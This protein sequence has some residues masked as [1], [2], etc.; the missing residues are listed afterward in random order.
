M[1]STTLLVLAF[2]VLMLLIGG[3]L[4]YIG[5]LTKARNRAC[6]VSAMENLEDNSSS[7]SIAFQ[8]VL[9]HHS[10]QND[11]VG[12]QVTVIFSD[13]RSWNGAAGYADIA[14]HCPLA[15][16]H[17]LY[18]G[19]ITKLFTA[20]LVMK[21][22]ENGS[23][24]LDQKINQWIQLP[25]AA[26]IT[27]RNL[28]SHTSGLPDYARDTWFQIRWFGLPSRMWEPDELIRVIQNKPV[29]FSPGSRYEYSNSNY[30]LLGMMLEKATEKPYPTILAENVSANL[31]MQD[32]YFLNYQDD[33]S[34]ANGYDKT[35][36]HLGRRN[37]T[38][39]R[40]SL[41]SGAYA[42]GGM[43]SNSQDVARF[44]HALFNGQVISNVS[45]ATM[46]TFIDA[47]E[48]DIPEQSGYGL[49]LRRLVIDG[50]SLIGHTGSIPG[51]SGIVMH[52]IEKNYTIAILSNLSTIEQVKL[53]VAIQKI[54]LK[55]GSG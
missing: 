12:L 48:E 3:W 46:Q 23:L 26:N 5:F 49:G 40:R 1:K 55:D 15:L 20:T 34:I 21:E 36:L 54:I 17:H 45:L 10:T 50:E 24:S 14:Q 4:G 9:N 37:L 11:E 32:T 53:L 41:E 33:I 42:A 22:I 13:G 29:R 39:F 2:I 28:L 7:T 6:H 51:Y 47:P 30:L 44:A 52:H 35:L 27:I 16:N 19:S 38:G 25:N 43:L 8:N 31:G 18:L